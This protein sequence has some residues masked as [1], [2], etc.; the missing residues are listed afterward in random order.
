[1]KEFVTETGYIT[2]A[3]RPLLPADYPGVPEEDLI[4]GSLVFTPP[5]SHAKV[6]LRDYHNWWRYEKAVNW[7]TPEGTDSNILGKGDYP[8]VH[9]AFE[10]ALKFCRWKKKKLPTEAQYE[11]AARGG[12]S[13]NSLFAWGDEETPNGKYLA[14]YWQGEFPYVLAYSSE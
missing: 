6:D 14:N 11:W 3:E 12:L 13:D 7:R 1:M 5:T 8:V 10:D 2:V 9:V 4:S